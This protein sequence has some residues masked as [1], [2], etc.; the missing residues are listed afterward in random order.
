MTFVPGGTP[1]I[2]TTPMEINP[3]NPVKFVFRETTGNALSFHSINDFCSTA[4]RLC[5]ELFVVSVPKRSVEFV[6]NRIDQEVVPVLLFV[7]EV[8]VFP[9]PVGFGNVKDRL[10]RLAKSYNL[11]FLDTFEKDVGSEKEERKKML[12]WIKGDVKKV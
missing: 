2:D 9:S 11:E 5:E 1:S 12:E 3:E 8:S 7:I 10:E 6:V 4:R